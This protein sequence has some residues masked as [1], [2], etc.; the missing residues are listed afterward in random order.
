MSICEPVSRDELLAAFLQLPA[1]VTANLRTLIA[2]VDYAARR[3]NSAIDYNLV[4]SYVEGTGTVGPWPNLGANETVDQATASVWIVQALLNYYADTGSAD[5]TKGVQNGTAP[6]EIKHNG[7]ATIWAGPARTMT[8]PNDVA[9]GDYIYLDDMVTTTLESVVVGFKYNGSG[10]PNVLVLRDNLPTAL[11][12]GAFFNVSLSEIIA[13]LELTT[14]QTTLT[15]TTVKANAAITATSTRVSSASPI[16]AGTNYSSVYVNY[17]AA[18]TP[19]SLGQVT[20]FT[21]LTQLPAAFVGWEYPESG[22]G[23]AVARALAPQQS[24]PIELPAVLSVVVPSE[25]PNDWQGI[26]NRMQRRRDWYT[27]APLTQNAA[28]QASIVTSINARNLIGLNS[29]VDLVQQLVTEIVLLSG[30][31]NTVTVDQSLT[32][33]FDRTVTRDGGVANPFAGVQPGDIV[34]IATVAYPVASYISDQT[35]TLSLSAVAGTT[36]ALNSVV[37]PYGT[38]EQ[39]NLYGGVAQAFGNESVS[40]VFPPNPFWAGEEVDGTLLV[41]ALAGLRG[42]TAPQ[43]TDRGVL[44]EA[45]WTVPQSEFEFF[46]FLNILG[47]FGVYVVEASDDGTGSIVLHANTTD[48]SETLTA[49]EGLVAN[50][51]AIRRYLYD[52]MACLLGQV[53]ITNASLDQIRV[54]ASNALNFLRNN[55]TVPG[56]GPVLVSGAVG[57]PTQNSAQLDRV[58]VP[59]SVTIAAGLESVVLDIVVTI[60]GA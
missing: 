49:R 4:G 39:V 11:T 12:A 40:L 57:Q 53:K 5:A 8:V 56:L 45:G 1:D 26:I 14:S 55:T 16:I 21:A 15:S 2:G 52:A 22:L 41:A 35:V 20:R 48:Q 3:Y 9:I 27:L 23:F 29:R 46:A 28:I 47:E 19:A 30:S 36:E 50:A 37:H 33:G 60:A 59:I 51:D 42:Y 13:N 38:E 32:T 10:E 25:D 31:G 6:N 24:P 44:L 17:R 58:D 34:T 54:T 7:G 18:R 43:G